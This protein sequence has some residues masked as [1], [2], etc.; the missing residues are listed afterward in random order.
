MRHLRFAL[1]LLAP[2]A[3][4]CTMSA[5]AQT[6]FTWP[7][8]SEHVAHY[9]NMENCLAAAGRVHSSVLRRE[10]LTQWRDTF[11]QN[12]RES[13]EPLPAAVSQTATQCAAQFAEAK[14]DIHDFA[15]A[16]QLFLIAGRDSDVAALVQRRVAAV[17]AKSSRERGAVVDSAVE[18]YVSAKPSRLEAAE[19]LLLHRVHTSTDRV[20]RLNTYA[21][22][23]RAS[24]EAGDTTRTIRVARWLVSI[25]DS[26]TVAERQSDEYERLLNGMGGDLLVYDAIDELTGLKT[27]MDSL[28]KSTAAYAAL[29]RGNWSR[30]TGERPEALQMPIGQRATP[31][32]ADYWFPAN[33]GSS[34]RPTPGRI[35]LVLF[36]EHTNCINQPSNDDAGSTAECASRMAEMRR[37]AKRFPSV[38]IDIVMSTHGQYMYLPPTAPAEEATLIKQLV[39]S[40]QVQGAVLGVTSTSFWR[41]PEPDARRIDKPR[42]NNEHYSFGK[43]WKVG[44]G[45][46]FLI[47]KDGVI[48]D[49]WRV[50]ENELGRFIETLMQRENKGN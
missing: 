2:G 48:S 10:D 39:D 37:L 29:E 6:R 41:L 24:R 5:S 30:A 26:L 28:R 3:V 9:T 19:G 42:P 1:A 21:T 7:D 18:M 38:E 20:E 35:A 50:R 16:M 49:A 27:R 33:A 4:V 17:P 8:T 15:P 45:S 36:L 11:P 40:Y 34:P 12:P 31:L 46:L 23:L 14:V 43:S 44:S 32:T 47:D 25:A 22:M 13:L